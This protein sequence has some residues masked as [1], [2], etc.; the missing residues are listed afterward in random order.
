[1]SIDAT[2]KLTAET[3]SFDVLSLSY[4]WSAVT[5]GLIRAEG[6]GGYELSKLAGTGSTTTSDTLSNATSSFALLAAL[7]SVEAVGVGTGISTSDLKPFDSDGVPQVNVDPSKISDA[8]L[9]HTD[10]T[11]A[12]ADTINGGDGHDI[13]FGDLVSF[14]SI[15]GSGIEAVQAFVATKL[16]VD[17][18]LVD[19]KVMHQ[20][21]SEHYTD[22][23][24][25]RT[26][27]GA[28]TLMGAVATTSSLVRAATITSMAAKATTS[29]S[30]APATTPCLAVKATICC[31]AGPATTC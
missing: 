19:A 13:I 20:Y 21:I 3:R 7:S 6:N 1:M 9:G 30:A 29:C 17:T 8:I 22:F 27:D 10:Q 23:D 31:S 15:P 24:L 16:G 5:T 12:G 26:N 18:S 2:G 28:D 11:I 4:K 25:S 14:D